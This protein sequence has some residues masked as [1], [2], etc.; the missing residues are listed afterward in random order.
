MF[1][2]LFHIFFLTPGLIPLIMAHIPAIGDLGLVVMYA[3]GV[4]VPLTFRMQENGLAYV[5]SQRLSIR[6]GFREDTIIVDE[7]IF[8]VVM[9]EL[10]HTLGRVSQRDE[11][12]NL[13]WSLPPGSYRVYGLTDSQMAASTEILTPRNSSTC[14]IKTPLP[15]DVKVKL[16]A[17]LETP[18]V[19]N[20]RFQ[21]VITLSSDEEGS[22]AK[23]PPKVIVSGN[24]P[25]LNHLSHDTISIL[26]FLKQLSRMPGKKNIL[27]KL[28]YSV[29]RHERVEYLPPVFDG[30]VIFEL[31][32]AGHTAT[33]S[34]AKSMQGMDKRYDGHVWTKTIT[35]NITND[36]GLS[37]R[38]STC[39]GHL[40]CNNKDYE[41]LFHR[42]R[43]FEVNETEFEGCT[44]QAFVVDQTPPTESTLVCKVCK[45][46]PAYIFTCGAKIY[47]VAGKINHT[48][49]C[50]HIG[51]HDHPVKVGDYR[52]TKV[53]ISGLIEEQ[54]EKTPQA[55]KSA[56]V[57]EASKVLIGNY[58]LQPDDAPPKK[59]S[60][61][62][63][64]PVLDRCK[65]TASPNIRNKV[66][67]FR[68]LRRY[69]VMDSIT[70]LRG[71]S[72]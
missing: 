42:P 17:D 15:R 59:F 21:S 57:L 66:M 65:D 40:R 69:G 24:T 22:P 53:E 3:D 50:I 58:L 35:T 62:E 71:I 19:E 5:T 31:P 20:V 64:V 70:K 9:S 44:L 47:Y 52:D 72:L 23:V 28:D 38:S 51:T 45:E 60:L 49:A 67:S 4:R 14:T 2:I 8:D 34:Q 54:I 10:T 33:R 25:T 6:F 30:A 11:N 41:Y 16:E 27:K 63:L 13:F 32:P 43:I 36:F 29:I 12:N 39:V 7:D 46:P 26:P 68:F 55:T 48:R 37:F 18:I 61:E 1:R 56:V